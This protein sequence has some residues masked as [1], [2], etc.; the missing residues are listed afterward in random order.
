MK[1]LHRCF[2]A[3]VIVC[4]VGIAVFL[5]G[6][7]CNGW[8][9]TVAK[10]YETVTYSIAAD[11]ISSLE[12]EL[13][14]ASVQT[15]F[16]DGGDIVI[17]YPVT[18]GLTGSVQ[19][20]AG[21]T[22]RFSNEISRWSFLWNTS[23]PTTYIRIPN[24][25]VLDLDLEVKAGTLTI[26]DG[27]YGD[28]EMEV[29]AGTLTV[30]NGTYGDVEMEVKAGTLKVGSIQCGNLTCAVHAGT[31]RLEGAQCSRFTSEVHAG[32][33]KAVRLDCPLISAEVSAGSLELTLTG[34]VT[35]Y[36]KFISVSA[37]SCNLTGG[38]ATTGNRSITATVSAGSAAIY[39]A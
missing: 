11:G 8:R 20:A 23:I 18:D 29:K 36:S 25:T 34:A 30:G 3:G 22:L 7:A 17:E 33:L 28:A 16:Y 24:G 37:G 1:A 4:I 12:I 19:T 13:S 6:L 2:I 15:Q 31:L 26:A 14:G 35:D 32:S 27:A 39:F 21:G 5:V 10:Q 9:L 38:A